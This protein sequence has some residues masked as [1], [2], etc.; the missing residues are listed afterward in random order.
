MAKITH[1]AI[2][3]K[4]LERAIKFYRE[5]FGF[6]IYYHKD[7][8]WAMLEL[9]GTTLSFVV[10]PQDTPPLPAGH[11]SHFGICTDTPEEVDQWYQKLSKKNLKGLQAPKIHRDK[12]YG[13]YLKDSEE[14]YLEVIHI[15]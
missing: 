1:V 14:N 8:D 5:N 13:F 3:V 10:T 11:P 12:S 7:I 4:N 6:Q 15:P 2:G 9:N